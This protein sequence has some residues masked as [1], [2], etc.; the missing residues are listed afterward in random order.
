MS[1]FTIGTPTNVS[2]F[3]EE[4]VVEDENITTDELPVEEPHV[5][6][7]DYT[8]P[9]FKIYNFEIS[10]LSIDIASLILT[11]VLIMVLLISESKK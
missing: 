1:I 11:S 3:D 4:V 5:Y 9:L 10:H 2:K 6:M 8:R 7:S